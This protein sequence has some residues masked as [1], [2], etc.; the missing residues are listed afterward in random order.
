MLLADRG[1]RRLGLGLGRRFRLDEVAEEDAVV[2]DQA[3]DGFA[4]VVPHM[5]LVCAVLGPMVG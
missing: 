1:R 4:E 3:F 5:P 2:G